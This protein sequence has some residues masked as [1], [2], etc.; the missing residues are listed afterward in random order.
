MPF[1]ERKNILENIVGVDEVIDF[2][3]DDLGSAIN[4][5]KKLKK[6]YP[7]ESIIFANGGDRNQNNI[8]EMSVKGIEFLFE[9]VGKDKKNSSSWILKN[10][11]FG[12][13]NRVW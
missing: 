1:T 9:V 10:W 12:S 6:L 4:A 8:P 11:K 2:E 7:D 3:D 5:L 13:E